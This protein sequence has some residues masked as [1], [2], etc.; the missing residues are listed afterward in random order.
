MAD[1][2][3]S[4][5]YLKE[6]FEYKDGDLI[7]KINKGTAKKGDIT[8]AYSS[9][10]YLNTVLHRKTYR[11]HRLIFLW[12]HG[13]LPKE[14]DHIDCNALNNRIEN[15]R[16]STR[17]ENCRNRK[18]TDKNTS[19]VKGVSWYKQTNRW[20]VQLQVNGKKY[21]FGYYKDIDYA[22]FVANAMR[23]KYHKDFSRIK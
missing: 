6:I 8:G 19:G 10:G 12:H 22:I 3:I 5:E 17:G 13:Y 7:W 20:K 23:Y 4:Q 1:K 9:S 14:V 2:I 15:L 16:P 21:N 11:T 18:V